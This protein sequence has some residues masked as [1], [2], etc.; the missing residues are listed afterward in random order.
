MEEGELSLLQSPPVGDAIRNERAIRDWLE[1]QLSALQKTSGQFL[2]DCMRVLAGR[3]QDGLENVDAAIEAEIAA[4][5][6][7]MQMQPV[8]M[9]NYRRFVVIRATSE[10]HIEWDQAGVRFF[11]T[12]S[13][14]C[15]DSRC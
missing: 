12:Q 6:T 3:I 5:L 11:V 13:A 2:E 4:D 14:I 7:S 9:D 10:D 15:A 1:L 8:I